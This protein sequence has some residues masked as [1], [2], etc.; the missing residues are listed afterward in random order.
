MSYKIIAVPTFMKALK[1]LVK[2]YPSLK[3]ELAVLF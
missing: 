3:T 1:K 2:K